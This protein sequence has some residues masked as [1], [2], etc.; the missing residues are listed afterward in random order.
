MV[1]DVIERDFDEFVV[2]RGLKSHM[3]DFDQHLL[4]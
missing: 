3:V 1:S 4:F 2:F